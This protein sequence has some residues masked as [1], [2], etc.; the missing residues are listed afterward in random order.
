MEHH[1]LHDGVMIGT[2]PPVPSPVS[3][4]VHPGVALHLPSD[5]EERQLEVLESE[6]LRRWR[7]APPLVWQAIVISD[8][9]SDNWGRIVA[10]RD[11]EQV[12]N[13]TKEHGRSTQQRMKDQTGKPGRAAGRYE[14]VHARNGSMPGA[15]LVPSRAP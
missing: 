8:L 15:T 6:L 10:G 1:H 11:L 3:L 13:L 14:P 5:Q 9:S 2:S 12:V 4:A 7:D